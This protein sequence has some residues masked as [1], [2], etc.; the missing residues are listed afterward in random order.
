MFGILQQ[1]FTTLRYDNYRYIRYAALQTCKY[2]D[3]TGILFPNCSELMWE[4]KWYLET[5]RKS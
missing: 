5:F 4:K 3:R 1:P 2:T